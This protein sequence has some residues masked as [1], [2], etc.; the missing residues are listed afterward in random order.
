MVQNRANALHTEPTLDL[1]KCFLRPTVRP[2]P[3][4]RPDLSPLC[5]LQGQGASHWELEVGRG[6]LRFLLWVQMSGSLRA[7]L[8]LLRMTG[9]GG[10]GK[11][12]LKH[13]ASGQDDLGAARVGGHFEVAD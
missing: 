8:L 9:S 7:P 6:P 2:P 3:V 12:A 5:R 13:L 4:F 10:D 1:D 11:T